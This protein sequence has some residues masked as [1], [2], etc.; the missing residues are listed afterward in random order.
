MK[1]F[2]GLSNWI[3]MDMG[4]SQVRI[5]RENKVILAEA[6][7]VAVDNIDGHVL[8]F[9]TE[10]LIHYH[11]APENISLEWPVQNGVIADYD[12]TKAMLRFFYPQIAS[13]CGVASDGDDLHSGR[14]ELGHAACAGGCFDP[15]RRAACVPS[16][17]AGGCGYRGGEGYAGTV[18]D[19]FSCHRA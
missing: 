12:M 7:T 16:S 15:R 18:C 4:S 3:G 11:K 8:G 1:M 5:Y 6:S 14:D 13:S 2:R 10:A 17:F 9:G 19:L